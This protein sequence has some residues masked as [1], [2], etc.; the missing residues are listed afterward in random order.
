MAIW[1]C[2]GIGILLF[3][4]QTQ[5]SFH[6]ASEILHLRV[7]LVVY[8]FVQL[9][10]ISLSREDSNAMVVEPMQSLS[11]DPKKASIFGAATIVSNK[12]IAS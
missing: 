6:A 7:I 3:V 10:E 1:V 2:D 4:Q 11:I 5:W 8:V 9:R 12:S